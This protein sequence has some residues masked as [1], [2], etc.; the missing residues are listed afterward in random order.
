M[1][2]HLKIAIY[3][4]LSLIAL[5]RLGLMCI[6]DRFFIRTSVMVALVHIYNFLSALSNEQQTIFF[7]LFTFQFKI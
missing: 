4:V 1:A 2:W 5:I 7:M 3:T 6:L